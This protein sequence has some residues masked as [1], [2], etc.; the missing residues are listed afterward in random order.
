[1]TEQLMVE[2]DERGV[3]TVT[4]NRPEVHNAFDDTL[5]S[6]LTSAFQNLDRDPDI[7]VL[8]LTGAGKS[9]S[10]GADMNW[11]RAM[12]SYEAEQNIE[13]ALRLAEL[14]A[15]LN[16]LHTPSIAM[17]NGAAFGGGVGLV[18]CCDIAVASDAA[19][20]SLSEVRLGLVP[21]V[22]SPY[23]ISAIGERQARRYF[24]TGEVMDA[25]TAQR[26]ALVHEV[27]AADALK[28]RVAE[29]TD[30][31]LSGGPAALR[32]CKA[33]IA[34]ISHKGVTASQALKHR[35]AELIAQ[36]RVSDEGQ[37]GL[38]AFL[39]KRPPAWRK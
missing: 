19:R 23:V 26:C 20:F 2:T 9:F 37:E 25:K 38:S 28:I 1:M 6:D 39:D 32:E 4:L 21:A 36:L 31:L 14:L 12:A 5:I 10:S 3:A 7:R 18:A 35:T 34:N 15:V 13:D 24:L 11:M 22:I 17:V 27:C 30:A 33:L 16:T 8:I 29:I